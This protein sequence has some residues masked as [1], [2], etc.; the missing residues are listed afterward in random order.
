MLKHKNNV[1]KM[2]M[3][4]KIMSFKTIVFQITILLMSKIMSYETIAYKSVN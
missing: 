3:G 2:V 1:R 4:S